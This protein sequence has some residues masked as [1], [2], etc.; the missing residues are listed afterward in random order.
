M[1]KFKLGRGQTGRIASPS[2]STKQK[3]DKPPLKKC[4]IVFGLFDMCLICKFHSALYYKD[5]KCVHLEHRKL[6]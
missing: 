2:P 4:Q 1:I 6:D 5:L 3:T